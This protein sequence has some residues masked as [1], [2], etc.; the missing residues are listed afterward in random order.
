VRL[1][2]IFR[3][4]FCFLITLIG[5]EKLRGTVRTYQPS[6]FGLNWDLLA[7]VFGQNSDSE[8]VATGCTLA[9]AGG[10]KN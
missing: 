5:E 1:T 4:G 7:G 3:R 10:S 9:T 6:G 2:K 8:G